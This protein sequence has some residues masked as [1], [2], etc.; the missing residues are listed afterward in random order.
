[1]PNSIQIRHGAP[2]YIRMPINR[3]ISDVTEQALGTVPPLGEFK[4][5]GCLV[6]EP[7]RHGTG[8][9]IFVVNDIF[10]ELQIARYAAN[11]K[12]PQTPIHAINGFGRAG[13]PCRHLDEKRIVI[14][15]YQCAGISGASIKTH[16]KS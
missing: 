7:G 4:Q 9:K 2:F 6:N 11:P 1:M 5:G 15:G 16:P 10:N 12:F 8:A 14:R 13:S 3:D